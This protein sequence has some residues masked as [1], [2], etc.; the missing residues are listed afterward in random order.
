M[1]FGPLLILAWGVLVLAGLIVMVVFG[2]QRGFRGAAMGL[3]VLLGAILSGAMVLAW[4][5]A[6]E[7]PAF[8]GSPLFIA[9]VVVGLAGMAAFALGVAAIGRDR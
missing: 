4:I 8:A 9:E 7:S 2:R 6:V 3:L 5:G 1:R